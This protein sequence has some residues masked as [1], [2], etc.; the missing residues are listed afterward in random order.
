MSGGRDENRVALVVKF[1]GAEDVWL[2][3]DQGT[4]LTTLELALSQLF[5]SEAADRLWHVVD[6]EMAPVGPAD[7]PEHMPLGGLLEPGQ[8]HTVQL[9]DVAPPVRG[10]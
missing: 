6:G 1:A 8:L 4:N 5:G 9:S 2:D 7:P 3:V 10:G